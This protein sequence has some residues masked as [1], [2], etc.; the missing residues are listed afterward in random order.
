MG[1]LDV[2]NLGKIVIIQG[3]VIRVSKPKTLEKIKKFKCTL[4]GFEIEV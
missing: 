1:E 4:C 3:T 2:H